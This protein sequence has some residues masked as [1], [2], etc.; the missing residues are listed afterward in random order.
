MTAY[1]V[2]LG[3]ESGNE[4]PTLEIVLTP[5]PVAARE[6][7]PDY[8]RALADLGGVLADEISM[9]PQT[10]AYLLDLARAR[11]RAR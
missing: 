10:V 6:P 11:E 9:P 4:D 1:A 2:A 7:S 3:G 5:A 8:E